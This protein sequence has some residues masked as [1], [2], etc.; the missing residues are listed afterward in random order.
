LR[1]AAVTTPEARLTTDEAAAE[2]RRLYTE[3]AAALAQASALLQAE[4]AESKSFLQADRNATALWQRLRE[5]REL[6]AKRWLA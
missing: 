4:G 2:Y 6:A 5:I 3:C 1:T